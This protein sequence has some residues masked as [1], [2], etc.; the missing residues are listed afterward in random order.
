MMAVFLAE[1]AAWRKYGARASLLVTV[2]A[3]GVV[4]MISG[5]QLLAFVCSLLAVQ[6]WLAWNCGFERWS[7]TMAWQWSWRHGLGG[8]AVIGGKLLAWLVLALGHFGLLLPLFFLALAEWGMPM[9]VFLTVLGSILVGGFFLVAFL[10]LPMGADSA[11]RGWPGCCLVIAWWV[12]GLLVHEIGL[13]N[14]LFQV[15]SLVDG[16][17]TGAFGIGRMMAAGAALLTSLAAG[18]LLGYLGRGRHHEND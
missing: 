16:S 1:L 10:L 11:L 6:L 3:T 12:A 5:G 15:W 8:M 4:W 9:P 14:P 18:G 17:D 13:A 2:C 7:V